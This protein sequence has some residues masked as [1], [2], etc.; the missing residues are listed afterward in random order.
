MEA[1]AMPAALRALPALL[2]LTQP[3]AASSLKTI[4]TFN[5]ADQGFAP[6][7]QILRDSAG[8]LYGITTNATYGG[9]TVYK[10]SPPATT[11]RHFTLLWRFVTGPVGIIPSP[12]LAAGAPNQFFGATVANSERENYGCGSVFTLTAGQPAQPISHLNHGPAGCYPNGPVNVA[13][14]GDVFAIA[15]NGGDAQ[16]GFGAITRFIPPAGTRTHWASRIIYSFRGQEDGFYPLQPMLLSASGA[17]YG[18]ALASSN[19]QAFPEPLFRLAPPAPHQK[20]WSFSVIYPFTSAECADGIGPLIEGTG[21]TIYGPCSD[22]LGQGGD[23]PGNIFSLTPPATAGAPWT[24]TVLWTF[25]GGADGGHPQT[26][27]TLAKSG[28]LYG[29]TSQGHG[30]IFRLAPPTTAAQT[31]WTQTTLWTF[32]GRDGDAPSSPLLITPAGTLIGTTATGGPNQNG[33][34]FELTP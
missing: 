13:P 29:T 33:T 9:G 10:L 26:G 5:G 11:G 19:G 17:L 1:R 31:T 14:N 22:N 15:P 27:L 23:Q 7:G 25:T 24:K 32:S 20:A 18:S 21:G 3:A 12:G 2:L 8:A 34:I 6:A 16:G 30:T 4:F 28:A